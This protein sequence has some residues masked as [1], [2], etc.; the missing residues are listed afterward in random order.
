MRSGIFPGAGMRSCSRGRHLGG[1]AA[2]GGAAKAGCGFRKR[3]C[4]PLLHGDADALP[5]TPA[6]PGA[7]RGARLAPG[8]G[9]GGT[10]GSGIYSRSQ[11]QGADKRRLLCWECCQE[12]PGAEEEI[13]QPGS[14][15]EVRAGNSGCSSIPARRE[16]GKI[17]EKTS[18][19]AA[20][21][22]R[23]APSSSRCSWIHPE[24]FDPCALTC[25]VSQK[26]LTLRD[27][28]VPY[29][30]TPEFHPVPKAVSRAFPTR[31]CRWKSFGGPKRGFL[32]RNVHAKAVECGT[33]F[34][35]QS[36]KHP[37]GILY[38]TVSY[39]ENFGQGESNLR[40]GM[41]RIPQG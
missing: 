26:I 2:P 30:D 14:S 10:E 11:E 9:K 39:L 18:A 20:G 40:P 19:G 6:G 16:P 7:A 35:C 3:P 41:V 21:M 34:P 4:I 31:I 25:R 15:R 24:G 33:H 27:A 29:L 32:A 12:H 17:R 23:G 5:I 36:P 13:K 22:G 38:L 37:C 28:L 8:L 1:R